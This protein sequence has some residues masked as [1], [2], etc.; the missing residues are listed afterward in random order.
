MIE[1][2]DNHVAH[3]TKRDFLFARHH[4][5]ALAASFIPGSCFASSFGSAALMAARG[6]INDPVTLPSAPSHAPPGSNVTIF[7]WGQNLSLLLRN[8]LPRSRRDNRRRLH[9]NRPPCCVPSH[10]TES[11]SRAENGRAVRRLVSAIALLS[12]DMP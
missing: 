1:P 9:R 11:M 8:D 10:H 3:F 6:S 12:P 4:W 7:P 2:A 5:F